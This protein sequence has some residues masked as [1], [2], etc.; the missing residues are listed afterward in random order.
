M[1]FLDQ[2]QKRRSIYAIGKNVTL[3]QAQVDQLIRD[4][5]KHSPSSFNSQSS[6]AVILFGD[7]HVKYW[8][9]V[10]E[11]LRKIVP[12]E[13]FAPTE[14]KMNGFIAG[15]GT[16]LFYEDQNVIKELQE[17]FALYA[18][19]FPIWSQHS[20]AIAQFATWTNLSEQTLVHLY[21]ITAHWVMLRQHRHLMCQRIGNS[22]HNWCLVQL[23][24]QLAK[25]HLLMMQS[26]LKA[27][28]N[29]HSYSYSYFIHRIG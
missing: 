16:V 23:K 18:D 17:K 15:Y 4:A 28:T 5:I 9:F 20:S 3:E 29:L 12:A 10:L 24:H 21:N 19:N 1:S 25:K 11:A 8:N 13:S 7:S 14:A 6:R 22:V 26:V 2:I 27:L